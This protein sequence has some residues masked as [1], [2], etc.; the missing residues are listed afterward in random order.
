MKADGNDLVADF[1]LES[2]WDALPSE[3]QQKARQA[4]L[5]VLGATISGTLTPVSKIAAGYAETA[6]RGE[7]ATILLHGARATAAGAAF[8]NGYAANGIDIDDC[9]KYTRGHPGAQLFPT[10]LAVSEKVGASGKEMLTAMAVGYEIAHRTARCWHDHHEVYQACGSWGSVACAAVA[11]KLMGLEKETIKHALGI[12]EYH[13]PNLPMMRDIDDPAMVK[14][15]IGWGAMNGIVAAELAQRGFTGIPSLLGFDKYHD[16]VATLGSEYIMAE[17]LWFKRW[18]CCAWGHPACL[19][20]LKVVEEND[21]KVDEITHLKVQVFHEGRRL[22]QRYPESTEEAQ[23]SIKWPLATVLL[24]GRIGPDQVLEHRFEDERVKTLVEKI[25]IV[26]DAEINRMYQLSWKGVDSPDAR[27]ASRVEI[28]LDDG[29]VLDSG[30]A[31]R[32]SIQWDEPS[33]EEKFHWVTGYVLDE[34]KR[35]QLVSM[36]WE[37]DSLADVKELTRLLR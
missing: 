31:D 5:D 32:D 15:G 11:V 16:W 34:P 35:E 3:V 7:E 22:S 13:A 36:A 30:L 19:A 1:I 8:A 37:F 2:D 20:A 6:F 12:A 4:L 18:S 29:R 14:H 10:A 24:D 9:A 26:E 21:V 25:E 33:L 28:T 23:F 17:G 27:F